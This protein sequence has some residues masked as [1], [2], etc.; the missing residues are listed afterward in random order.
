MKGICTV[1]LSAAVIALAT[2][3]QAQGLDDQGLRA[4]EHRLTERLNRQQLEYRVMP[5]PN[6]HRPF[7]WVRRWVW[8]NYWGDYHLA[9]VPRYS[10]YRDVSYVRSSHRTPGAAVSDGSGDDS[11]QRKPAKASSANAAKPDKEARIASLD[12]R[13]MPSGTAAKPALNAAPGLTKPLT[14]AEIRSAVPLDKVTDPKQYLSNIAIKSLWGDAIG[15][16][17]SVD[18]SGGSIKSLQ[19][20]VEGKSVRFDPVRLK[21]VKSRN[22]LITAMSKSDVEKLPSGDRS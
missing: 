13:N 16:V 14:P 6:P 11:V 9:W 10:Q 7:V 8:D 18:S 21:Y 2:A 15:H 3:A 1:L 22:L 19:A 5:R 20:D 17:R 12:T 4:D